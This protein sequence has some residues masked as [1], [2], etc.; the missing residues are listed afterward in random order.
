M[1]RIRAVLGD[2]PIPEESPAAPLQQH[3]DLGGAP[4]AGPGQCPASAR[5]DEPVATNGEAVMSAPAV[6]A[7][8]AQTLRTGRGA[9]LRATRGNSGGAPLRARGPVRLP[10]LD[11]VAVCGGL[12]AL[13]AIG[14]MEGP[15]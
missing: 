2:S 9:V 11:S 7:S 1:T 10:P 14:L 15:V 4:A 3:H 5:E 13:A 12:A 6:S 8:V